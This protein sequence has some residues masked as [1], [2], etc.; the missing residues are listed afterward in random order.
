MNNFF[1]KAAQL[2]VGSAVIG[3]TIVAA[4]AGALE[5]TAEGKTYE[6]KLVLGSWTDNDEDTDPFN[7]ENT[8]WFGTEALVIALSRE[9][10]TEAEMQQLWEGAGLIW[11]PEELR[12]ANFG[13]QVI[14]GLV[15]V[16]SAT[17]ANGSQA[18]FGSSGST[19]AFNNSNPFNVWVYGEEKETEATA[20]PTPATVVPGLL[21]IGLSAIRKRR[22]ISSEDV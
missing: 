9:I 12:R 3:L 10:D 13:W 7:L 2:G 8:P 1:Q 16:E 20:V 14:D 17:W 11:D 21:G 5:L 18:V 6:V 22:G 15:N 19:Q 4:P